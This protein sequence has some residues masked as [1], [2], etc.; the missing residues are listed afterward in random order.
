MNDT[1]SAPIQNKLALAVLALTF[2]AATWATPESS[3]A[4]KSTPIVS[5]AVDKVAAELLEPGQAFKPQLRFRDPWTAE[6]RFD[7]AP[8]YYLYRDRLRVEGE[9]K[10]PAVARRPNGARGDEAKPAKS[11]FVLSLPQGRYVDDP[12]FGRVEIFDKQVVLLVD[13]AILA[14]PASAV[15][16]SKSTRGANGA[17]SPPK[18]ATKFLVTSQGCAAAGVCFPPQQHEFVLPAT[19]S[20]AK[21]AA[22]SESPWI[23][24]LGSLTSLGFG[25][26]A[27]LAPFSPQK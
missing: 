9:F 26:P 13:L 17:P 11:Q 23:L 16:E 25:R 20:K 5:P 7:V 8:G 27:S 1:A 19:V 22:R 6:I 4:A 10:L 12:T 18:M 15:I 21:A 2:C 14:L 24:P 3:A